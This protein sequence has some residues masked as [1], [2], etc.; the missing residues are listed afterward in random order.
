MGSGKIPD[1]PTCRK[2]SY[3]KVF[4]AAPVTGG[5]KAVRLS[6]VDA[7]VA[8]FSPCA[9]VWLYDATEASRDTNLLRA[10]LQQALGQTLDDYPHFAGQL[11]WATSNNNNSEPLRLGRP[12]VTYGTREDPGVEFTVAAY[13]G[14]LAALV[15][16][17]E[18]RRGGN[19]RVWIATDFPQDELLPGAELAFESHLG[20]FEGLPGASA[21]VTTFSCGGFAVGIKITHCLSDAVCLVQFAKAWSARAGALFSPSEETLA[22]GPS[23]PPSSSSPPRAVFDPS[24]LDRH[25]GLQGQHMDDDKIRLARSLPMHRYDWWRTDAPGYPAWA[26]A[27]SAATRPTAAQLR[28]VT[29]SPSTAPPWTTW[30]AA[31]PVAHAQ[32]RFGGDEVRR[33]KAA[34]QADLLKEEEEDRGVVVGGGGS[35][36]ISRLDALLAH[37][38]ILINRARAIDLDDNDGNDEPVYMDLTL[39]LRTRVDPPLPATFAGSPL[40]LA[41][42]A[43]SS[44]SSSLGAVALAVR[45]AVARFTP[46]AVAAYLHDAAHEVSPQRL[47]QAFLGRRH[48]LVT[49]WARAG[50]YAEVGDFVSGGGGA[51]RPSRPPRYVQGR[52]PRVDGCCQVMD[53]VGE[54]GRDFEVSLCLETGALGRLVRDERLGAYSQA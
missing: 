3:Q 15:P 5:E 21:Q 19:Q 28:D 31:A 6:I 52:M 36:S 32:I 1:T 39:G 26:A 20:R 11:R 53:G 47:W 38:W 51:S 22:V 33:I 45:Q 23:S 2:I 9:A 14:A 8:R 13:D 18:A 48:T 43:L 10:H 40:L 17:E 30:D 49:S 44:S 35:S 7:T 25:A 42:V 12:V 37:V 34:A 46:D 50:C 4:P 29:L 54:D 24:L 41:H 16:S 27:S